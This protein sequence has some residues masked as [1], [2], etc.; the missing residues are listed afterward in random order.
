MYTVIVS[1]DPYIAR[2]FFTR[3]IYITRALITAHMACEALKGLHGGCVAI[4]GLV[5][6][7]FNWTHEALGRSP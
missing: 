6:M 5:A 7:A 1:Y 4:R 3:C 2:Q